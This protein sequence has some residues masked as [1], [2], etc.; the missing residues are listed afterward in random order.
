M[1]AV[2]ESAALIPD[3]RGLRYRWPKA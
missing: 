3:N 1:A 2:V